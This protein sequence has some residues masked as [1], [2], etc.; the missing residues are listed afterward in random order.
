M[1]SSREDESMEG[2]RRA[3]CALQPSMT[4]GILANRMISRADTGPG[5]FES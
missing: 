4:D 2:H 1:L 5:E 3:N